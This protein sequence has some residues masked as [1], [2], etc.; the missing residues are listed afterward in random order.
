M[1]KKWGVKGDGGR[2][3]AL[4]EEGLTFYSVQPRHDDQRV[5]NSGIWWANKEV[6]K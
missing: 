3:T 2:D 6:A 4:V 5:T 1:D